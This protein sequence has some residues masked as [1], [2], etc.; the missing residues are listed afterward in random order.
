M[1]S[2]TW[3][4]LEGLLQ[5]SAIAIA[6]EDSLEREQYEG[7]R[8]FKTRLDILEA[9]VRSKVR[10]PYSERFCGLIA[11]IR[12]VQQQ[13]DRIIHSSWGGDAVRDGTAE[14][15]GPFNH[16]KPYPSFEWKLDF[17]G[18]RAVAARIDDITARWIEQTLDGIER[19][20]LLSEALK[21]KLH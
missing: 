5:V 19:P 16:F 10:S 9:L 2:V 15:L 14:A 1:V 18:I 4:H 6:G 8:S 20:G 7:T 3:S 21:D 17:G 13:R 11:D 12:N